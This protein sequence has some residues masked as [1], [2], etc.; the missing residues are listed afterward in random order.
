[1]N[2]S[3]GYSCLSSVLQE[4]RKCGCSLGFLYHFSSITKHDIYCYHKLHFYSGSVFLTSAGPVT[5]WA[6]PMLY[7]WQNNCFSI[8][9]KHLALMQVHRNCQPL[10]GWTD[11][12]TPLLVQNQISLLSHPSALFVMPVHAKPHINPQIGSDYVNCYLGNIN[13]CHLQNTAALLCRHDHSWHTQ[14]AHSP[15]SLDQFVIQPMLLHLQCL[16]YLN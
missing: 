12:V 11:I 4:E 9:H 3:S 5:I 10:K 15:A 8:C 16:Q 6:F 13:L 7:L 14:F 1:M 2:S